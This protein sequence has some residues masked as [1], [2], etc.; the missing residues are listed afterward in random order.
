[1]LEPFSGS[2]TVFYIAVCPNDATVI[3]G[4]RRFLRELSS[5]YQVSGILTNES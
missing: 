5:V 4:T 1:M 3:E 2:R